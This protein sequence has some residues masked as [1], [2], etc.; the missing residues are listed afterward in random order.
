V[1]SELIAP[2]L[3][4]YTNNAFAD[5]L[6]NVTLIPARPVGRATPAPEAT[7]L[8]T[9]ISDAITVALPCAVPAAETAALTLA[10]KNAPHA[11]LPETVSDVRVPTL[12]MFGCA[13]VVTVPAVP[14]VAT[15]KFATCVVDDTT[16]G[17]VPVATFEM[18]CGVVILAVA[19]NCV[20]VKLTIPA[21][22]VFVA[23]SVSAVLPNVVEAFANLACASVPVEILLAFRSVSAAPLPL[24]API[25]VVAY[26]APLLV[27]ATNDAFAVSATLPVRALANTKNALPLLCV[28]TLILS[29]TLA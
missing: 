29:A 16:N 12:V 4:G 10:S 26:N 2:P 23:P 24:T 5:V 17:A 13:A 27:L 20:D 1:A 21:T 7:V 3:A 11:K 8:T 22:V 28:V 25:N 6:I 15:F 18:N 19:N 9:L 14:A